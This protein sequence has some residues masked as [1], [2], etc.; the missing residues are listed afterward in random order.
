MYL[1]FLLGTVQVT[2]RISNKT[3]YNPGDQVVLAA[4]MNKCHF[5]DKDTEK[6]ID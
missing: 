1:Y 2:A 6:F 5:F 4:N 3:K